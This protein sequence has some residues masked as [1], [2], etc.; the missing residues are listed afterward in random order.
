MV[1][2]L[3]LVYVCGSSWDLFSRPFALELF[4]AAQFFTWLSMIRC[5]GFAVFPLVFL[6]VYVYIPHWFRTRFWVT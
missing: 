6:R 3:Y 1:V 5:I 2:D 4:L